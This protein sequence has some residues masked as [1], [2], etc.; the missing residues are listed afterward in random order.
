VIL[1]AAVVLGVVITCAFAYSQMRLEEQKTEAQSVQKATAV[2]ET[3]RTSFHDQQYLLEMIRGFYSS[4]SFVSRD[5]FTTF[6]TPMIDQT[7][8]ITSIQWLPRVTSTDKAEYEIAARRDGMERFIITDYAPDGKIVPARSRDVYYP[9]YYVEPYKSNESL[10]GIDLYSIAAMRQAMDLAVEQGEIVSLV[11]ERGYAK[12]SSQRS[13]LYLIMPEYKPG[14]VN[15]TASG[16]KAN[17][18]GCTVVTV[19][20]DSIM[21]AAISTLL[22]GCVNVN[23]LDKSTG[24]SVRHFS[25]AGSQ[26]HGARADHTSEISTSQQTGSI[27]VGDK[28]WIVA[29]GVHHQMSNPLDIVPGTLIVGLI[30]TCLSTWLLRNLFRRAALV[31]NLVDE[32][33]AALT[34]EIAEREQAEESLIASKDETDRVNKELESAATLARELAHRAEAASKTKGEF[35]AS[36]SHEIRTPMNGIIGMTGLLL[37]TRMTEEQKDYAQI[38]R[39]CG[40][41]LLTLIN[42]ILDFSK[43]EA[44]KLDLEVLDFD[45][46]TAVEETSDILRSKVHDK[47]LKFSCLVD[48]GCPTMLRGDPGRLRQVLINLAN[49]AVKFTETGEVAI[50]VTLDA[51]TPAK[52]TIRCAVR[53][54][55]IGIPVDQMDRLFKSFSQVDSSMTRKY[56]GTGLGLA[57]SKQIVDLMGGQIGAES[58]HGAGSTFWFTVVLDKQP[59]QFDRQPAVTRQ[60]VNRQSQSPQPVVTPDSVSEDRKR[61]IRILLAEDNIINQKVALRILEA[62]LGYRADAVANGS[63]AIESL[64]RQDYDL[65]LMDCQMPEMDGYEATRSIRDPNSSVRNHNIPIVAMTANAMKGDREICLAAG[66]DD[67][68]AKPIDIWKLAEAIERNLPDLCG[69]DPELV[70]ANS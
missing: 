24:E 18:A 25:A 60:S 49:N 47:N 22:D 68:V 43:M 1:L 50:S 40:D 63:E 58:E 32:R 12:D 28:T 57:I 17:V 5:E 36:M 64:S 37:D 45:L 29:C 9:V 46:R 30:F 23:V 48:P 10:L 51:E 67:Y 44:G 31:Q 14:A 65:V 19:D 7:L 15:F 35:L 39:I 16:R 8:G 21:N 55:G 33:T 38:V 34:Q 70:G 66:M 11:A 20:V 6:V 42:D 52:A 41:Q 61:R 54:T 4:S 59:Q 13:V 3:L 27:D 53:D 56:G 62:K 26:Y 69:Q 2:V